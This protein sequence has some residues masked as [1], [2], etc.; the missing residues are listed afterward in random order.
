MTVQY[1]NSK[2]KGGG[3][4]IAQKQNEDVNRVNGGIWLGAFE[5]LLPCIGC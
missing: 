5:I 4:T 3:G 2:K 1:S